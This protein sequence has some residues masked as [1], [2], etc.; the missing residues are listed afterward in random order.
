V[1][2][3]QQNG[4]GLS[5]DSARRLGWATCP[6]RTKCEAAGSGWY[7]DD[8]DSPTRVVACPATCDVVENLVEARV[9]VLVSCAI[10]P[11]LFSVMRKSS[12]P[13]GTERSSVT[14]QLGSI[15]CML[16]RVSRY[17]RISGCDMATAFSIEPRRAWVTEA[18]S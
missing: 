11:A 15:A 14:C 4:C 5:S 6:L 9:E 16:T 10:E 13:P 2:D 8:G 3:G 18:S 12:D 1:T 17:N 7:Y